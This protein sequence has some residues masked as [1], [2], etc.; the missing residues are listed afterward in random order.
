MDDN[1]NNRQGCLSFEDVFVPKQWELRQFGFIVALCQTKA[2]L[3][4]N[5]FT[6]SSSNSELTK[7][8]FVR[9]LA[10]ELVENEIWVN[11]KGAE[12]RREQRYTQ[13]KRK[14]AEMHELCKIPAGRG[15][16]NGRSFRKVKQMYQKYKG[17]YKCGMFTRTYCICDKV[18]ML[19]SECYAIH[20]S[21]HY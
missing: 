16:W 11:E 4:Y 7:A 14:R 2:F 15:K 5:Y 1:N 13:R 6:R 8:E 18:L 12:E 20:K 3:A 21:E 9:A 19:C 10:K 17:S